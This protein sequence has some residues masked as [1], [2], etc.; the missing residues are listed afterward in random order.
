MRVLIES[1]RDRLRTPLLVGV[2]VRRMSAHGSQWRVH[3]DGED[4]WDAD[5][6]VLAC[7]AYVQAEMV[8]DVDRELAHEINAIQYAPVAVVSLGFRQE[9]LP[10]PLDGF[11]FIAP[12]RTRRD[13]LGAQWCSS[14]YPHRAPDGK[15]LVRVLAGGWNRR[16][17]VNW[18]DDQLLAAVRSEL[19]I[20]MK[21]EKPPVFH[22][23]VR[24]PNAIP[25]YHLGHLDRVARIENLVA[26][27]PGLFITGNAYHGIAMNDCTE[28]GP[29]VARHV[30]AFL[31]T[32]NW[33]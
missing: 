23:I 22:R 5:A 14:I 3:G 18:P 33:L 31:R 2:A 13:I 21:I 8:A 12:Q 19:R 11:G 25:Q 29:E 15:V 17:V 32:R 30:E 7:P 24:W 16:D 9:Q 10:G 4:H 6:V 28:R 26:K 27:H 20:T 1:L